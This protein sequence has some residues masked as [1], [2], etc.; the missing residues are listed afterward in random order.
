MNRTTFIFILF[1]ISIKSLSQ[2]SEDTLKINFAFFF[3]HEKLE[4]GKKFISKSND[5]LEITSLKFYVSNINLE[6]ADDTKQTYDGNFLMDIENKSNSITIKLKNEENNK[7]I[8]KVT[9]YIGIDSLTNV[10]GALEGDLDPTKGMY[11]AWQ[12]GYINFKMEGKSKNCLTP[13]NK[14]QF[15]IGGYLAPFESIRKV[16][17]Y[18]SKKEVFVKVDVSKLFSEIKLSET[19]SVMIPG[20]KA[21]FMANLVTKMFYLN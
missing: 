3:S 9:F 20:K 11:W 21:V 1:L 13:K 19:N 8:N 10:S 6:F 7:K 16:S 14:F 15:H 17:L 5:S 4:L 2:N 18:P 12:S